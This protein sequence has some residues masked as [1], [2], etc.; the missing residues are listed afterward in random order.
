[1]A[2]RKTPNPDP[3]F[4]VN[5]DFT[6]FKPCIKCGKRTRKFDTCSSCREKENVCQAKNRFYI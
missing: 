6:G 1:M 2:A 5:P 3:K 4:I